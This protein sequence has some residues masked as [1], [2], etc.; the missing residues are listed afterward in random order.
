MM[1]SDF[2][3]WAKL[4]SGLGKGAQAPQFSISPFQFLKTNFANGRTPIFR[5][6][7]LTNFQKSPGLELY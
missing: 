4:L 3:A 7:N 6:L 2:L 1:V 5:V